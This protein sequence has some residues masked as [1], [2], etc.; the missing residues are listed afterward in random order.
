MKIAEMLGESKYVQKFLLEISSPSVGARCRFTFDN[1]SQATNSKQYIEAT[2]IRP[3]DNRTLR[4]LCDLVFVG[5]TSTTTAPVVGVKNESN[6]KYIY[7]FDGLQTPDG[8]LIPTNYVQ[9][10]YKEGSVWQKGSEFYFDPGTAGIEKI[11]RTAA[12]LLNL[13]CSSS[14]GDDF[15]ALQT[16]AKSFVTEL[17]E[18]SVDPEE[19]AAINLDNSVKTL[20]T[21]STT[22]LT[23]NISPTTALEKGIEWSSTNTSV[24]TVN[25]KGIVSAINPGSA[26]IIAKTIDGN[27]TDACRIS[28]VTLAKAIQLSCSNLVLYT[29]SGSQTIEATVF[30]EGTSN[31]VLKWSCSNPTV[32]SIDSHGRITP[33]KAGYTTITAA[34]TDG[35]GVTAT[36]DVHILQHVESVSLDSTSALLNVGDTKQLTATVSPTDASNKNV[37]WESSHPE[38]VSVSNTGMLTALKIGKAQIS[39]TTQDSKKEA[40]CTVEVTQYVS[41]ITLNTTSASM[42]VNE[43]L[44]LSA[45]IKPTDASNKAV[46]WTSSNSKIATVN[47]TGLVTA[48]TPGTVTISVSSQDGTGIVAQCTI[49]VKQ[50]VSSIS[51]SSSSL[52]LTL[53]QSKNL[54]VTISPANA[55]N[56]KYSVINTNSSIVEIW[57]NGKTITITPIGVGSTQLT[58]SSEDGGYTATCNITVSLSK[59]PIHLALAVKKNGVRYYIPQSA[60]STF[61]RSGYT[62]EGIAVVSGTTAFILALDNASTSAQS[63]S[64]ANTLGTLPSVSQAQV[65][66]QYWSSINNALTTYGGT[67]LGTRTYWTKEHTELSSRGGYCYSSSGVTSS[68][69]QYKY[70][71]RKVIATL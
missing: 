3:E 59:T 32:A 36:C 1:V 46:V 71:A 42:Y 53:G 7:A 15:P 41:E 54:T 65:I 17:L 29:N 50:H 2:F 5:L 40:I 39:V 22:T 26:T 66:T 16:T 24:A 61:N 13:D 48:L 67:A 60:Y 19:V 63:F 47:E 4:T 31:K 18:H 43:S 10:W 23:A 28:V 8:S 38:I 35:S 56:T 45:T 68:P 34:A 27:F 44:Q 14:L 57:Q 33:I 37:I 69:I 25:Q 12:I 52:N 49:T 58:V 55:T 20:P 51:L 70:Y 62:T 30:P 21:G 11:K 9:F 64:N 6:N